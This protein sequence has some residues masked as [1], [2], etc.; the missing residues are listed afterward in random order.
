MPEPQAQDELLYLGI[1]GGGTKCSAILTCS[2]HNSLGRGLAGPAN[3]FR[4]PEQTIDSIEKAT[5]LALR[6][7]GL[8]Q[9]DLSR[10]IAG[11][12][13]AGVNLPIVYETMSKW[14]HPYKE[15]FLT[16]DLEIA[17][18]GAHDGHDGGVIVVGTGSS[19]CSIVNG[20]VLIIGAHGFEFGDTSSGAWLGRQ[21]IRAVLLAEDDLGPK[22]QLTESVSEALG[23]NGV[24]IVEKM[25]GAKPSDFASLAGLVFAAADKGDEVATDIIQQGASYLSHMVRKLASTNP[26]AISVLGGLKDLILPWLDDDVRMQLVAAKNAADVG[27]V[28]YAEQKHREMEATA[29]V[30]RPSN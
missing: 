18:A 12:G 9:D 26:P 28:I 29:K 17:C 3:P 22:T 15:M 11:V 24:S 13:L 19:G 2:K 27:A 1:D 30:S 5:T 21:A 10:V 7:A 6:D 25:V 20:E 16:T 8:S 23:S 4:G 14:K